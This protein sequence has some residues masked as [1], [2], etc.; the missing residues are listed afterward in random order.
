MDPGMGVMPVFA[1]QPAEGIL[2]RPGGGG[3]HVRLYRRK[4]EDIL[5]GKIIRD[6]DPFR[7]DMVERQHFG[8]R[9]VWNPGHIRFAEVILYGN[10]VMLENGNIPIQVLSFEGVGF[11]APIPW[12]FTIGFQ[13]LKEAAP[14]LAVII[15]LAVVNF[16][17]TLN[18]VESANTAGDNYPIRETMIVDAIASAIGGVFG[19]PYPNCVFIGH[20]GYK[21]MGARM[22]YSLLNGILMT[23]MALF[24][25]FG[26]M[27]KIIP[28]SAV[29][30]ILIFI[31]LV[32]IEIAFTAVPKAHQ[33]AVAAVFLISSAS[34]Y[35]SR[36][37]A[38]RCAMPWK[39]RR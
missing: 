35:A 38:A 16:I 8:L 7:I 3:V 27:S 28:T 15:P 5:S 33:A 32:N 37:P 18:N 10:V 17:S 20:P 13:A 21:R 6:L 36:S 12:F 31:G 22:G 4:M 29:T 39:R 9:A 1:Q 24:G 11:Y 26:F 23:V 19:C 14:F 34:R 30:P 25:L 2:H